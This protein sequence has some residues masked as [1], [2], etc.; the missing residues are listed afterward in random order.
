VCPSFACAD[1]RVPKPSPWR[2]FGMLRMSGGEAVNEA[3]DT[4]N[5]GRTTILHGAAPPRPGA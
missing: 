3:V 4:V 5:A 2:A 1:H